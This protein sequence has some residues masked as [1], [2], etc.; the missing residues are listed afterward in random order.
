MTHRS[1]AARG[2]RRTWPG[3]RRRSPRLRLAPVGSCAGRCPSTRVHFRAGWG[4]RDRGRLG[5][6]RAWLDRAL[7]EI[8]VAW[9]RTTCSDAAVA[10]DLHLLRRALGYMCPGSD[11]AWLLPIAKRIATRAQP[12]PPRLHLV[13]SDQLYALSDRA[14]LRRF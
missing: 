7:A 8:Y 12:K 11:W 13:S 14:K 9:R 10:N 2:G 6:T 1:G 5:D 4:R 3:R